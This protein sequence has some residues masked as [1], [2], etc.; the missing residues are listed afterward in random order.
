MS[1]DVPSIL[2]KMLGIPVIERY[3]TKLE[4]CVLCE[5]ERILNSYSKSLPE[6]GL[7]LPPKDL[8]KALN[9]MAN[10]TFP[11]Q[12][13]LDLTDESMCNIKKGTHIASLLNETDLTIWDE[14]PMN[15]RRCFETLDWSLRDILDTP[16]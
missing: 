6:F 7:P 15:D 5:V 9:N 3:D 1:K 8:L 4:A 2:S 11:I 12:L 13:P 10:N 14:A 16:K